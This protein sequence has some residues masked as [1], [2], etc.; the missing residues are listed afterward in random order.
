LNLG[1]FAGG[2][3]CRMS[4]NIVLLKIGPKI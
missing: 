1:I 4:Y 2:N 3:D